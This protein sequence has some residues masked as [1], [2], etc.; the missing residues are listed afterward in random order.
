[1]S[2][3]FGVDQLLSREVGLRV[4]L[5][6]GLV[7]TR[8]VGLRVEL[9][10]LPAPLDNVLFCGVSV[11]RKFVPGLVVGVPKSQWPGRGASPGVFRFS[12]GGLGWIGGEKW[13]EMDWGGLGRLRRIGVDWGGLR[14]IGGEKW[15]EV[16][17][18]DRIA[19]KPSLLRG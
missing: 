13:I 14:G 9:V 6:L 19:S 5:V 2:C 18:A 12:G 10:R 8:P 4:E 17:W 1:M 11:R 15:I 3:R 16:D 7:A